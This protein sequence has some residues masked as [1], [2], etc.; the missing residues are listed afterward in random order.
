MVAWMIRASCAVLGDTMPAVRLPAL[1]LAVGSSILTYWLTL[2]LFR[3]DRMALGAVLLSHLV[4]MF[5]AG[6]V[7]M[8]IDPP[9]FFFW[10]LATCF[11]VKA[12]FDDRKWAWIALGVAIG[13]GFWAKFTMLFWLVGLL[14]FLIVDRNSRRWLRSSWPWIAVGISLLFTVPIIVWNIRHGWVS[15]RHI[16]KDAGPGG[17]AGFHPMNFVEYIA[18]Q[19][20]AVGPTMAAIVIGSILFALRHKRD[21]SSE[22]RAM[23]YLLVMGL[24]L[25]LVIGLLTFVTKAQVNWPAP[26][27]FALL[28][29]AAYFLATRMQDLATWRRWR[30]IFWITVIFGIATTPIAHNTNLLYRP[31]NKIGQ[32]LGRKSISPRQW[33]P[34]FRLRGWR[35]FG[36]AISSELAKLPAGSMVMCEDYQSTAEAAFYVDGQPATYYVGSW[37][38]DPA[39]LSQYDLWPDRRLDRADLHGHDAIYFGHDGE[40]GSGLPPADFVA[41]FDSV[42]KLPEIKIVREGLQIRSFRLWRCKGFKGM[43][44]AAILKKY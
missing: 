2:R 26:S 40:A 36:Q 7:L 28:I 13:L 44:R 39:R 41:A 27:Y 9:F 25:F 16:V 5:V 14:L 18:G 15:A 35:E 23:R 30:G 34:T 37:L 3:S 8:T 17:H 43:H 20:G 31:I 38:A 24:P 33:D 22:A 6:S 11:A 10:A 21:D 42:E 29:L 19:I 1:I 32:M 4:P 12:V